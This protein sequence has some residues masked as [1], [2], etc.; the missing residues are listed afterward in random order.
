MDFLT[1]DELLNRMRLN[2]GLA[3][4]PAFAVIQKSVSD[5]A[6]L[7]R[8]IYDCL[9]LTRD[10]E[11]IRQWFHQELL[12]EFPRVTPLQLF[13]AGD[14]RVGVVEAV[15]IQEFCRAAPPEIFPSAS[16]ADARNPAGE[17]DMIRRLL[18][19]RRF[20]PPSDDDPDSESVQEG[21]PQEDWSVHDP[22]HRGRSFVLQPTIKIA[23]A[24]MR[25]SDDQDGVAFRELLQVAAR[26]PAQEIRMSVVKAA[27]NLIGHPE[28][29]D[30]LANMRDD[31][32]DEIREKALSGLIRAADHAEM[33]WRIAPFA[34]DENRQIRRMA[35][36]ALF[37]K[38]LAPEIRKGLMWLAFDPAPE[39]RAMA[40]EVFR[41]EERAAMLSTLCKRAAAGEPVSLFDLKIIASEAEVDPSTR[42]DVFLRRLSALVEREDG[43]NAAVDTVSALSYW[44]KDVPVE[45]WRAAERVW[46]RWGPETEKILPLSLENRPAADIWP[47]LQAVLPQP[48]SSEAVLSRIKL[49]EIA[50][51][52][53]RDLGSDAFET[54][55]TMIF[56]R[57]IDGRARA[58][59]VH[60]L[61]C[62][63]QRA[64]PLEL[65]ARLLA[66]PAVELRLKKTAL[67]VLRTLANCAQGPVASEITRQLSWSVE[68][69]EEGVSAAAKEYLADL[70][71]RYAT[72]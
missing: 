9:Y 51:R 55:T 6:E 38:E 45:I 69:L 62:F 23:R 26:D 66:D 18:G 65:T 8:V 30:L 31:L 50:G 21:W 72:L 13:A 57:R 4:T 29:A 64:E 3:D 40:R 15:L 48:V 37:E 71:D 34:H 7:M 17:I 52:V 25:L 19:E 49:G 59:M 60:G 2:W 1:T 14:Y 43:E 70:P 47:L 10:T 16:S 12:K 54:L 63:E 44:R 46:R 27:A 32:K 67:G 68:N 33:H 36:A 53:V 58:I 24:I 11:A 20:T 42:R 56:D 22:A 35:L 39:V 61:N 5:H 28:M 41:S